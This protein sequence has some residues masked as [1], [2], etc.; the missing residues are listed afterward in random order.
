MSV[1]AIFVPLLLLGLFAC[2]EKER[3]PLATV[4]TGFTYAG[5]FVT[6]EATATTSASYSLRATGPNSYTT[7]DT[8]EIVSLTLKAVL[9]KDPPALLLSY[10][11]PCGHTIYHLTNV[12]YLS[13]KDTD[14]PVFF[15]HITGTLRETSDGSFEG[16]FTNTQP[17][18]SP[19]GEGRFTHVPVV[20]R[21]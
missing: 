12:I 6:C 5:R 3:L 17:G 21:Y 14:A 7:V 1:R 20:K 19:L 13:G 18:S 16:A 4:P 15:T 10:E 8:T 11:R 2:T 9:A